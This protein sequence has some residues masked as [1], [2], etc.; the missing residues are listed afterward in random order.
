MKTGVRGAGWATTSISNVWP[1]SPPLRSGV[2][3]P[4]AQPKSGQRDGSEST[5][6]VAAT[7]GSGTGR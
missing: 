6:S 3:R 5:G 2:K 7:D 1:A 4:P